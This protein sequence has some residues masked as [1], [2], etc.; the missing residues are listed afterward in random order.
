MAG[1]LVCGLNAIGEPA[2]IAPYLS[3]ERERSH[4]NL[5]TS[6]GAVACYFRCKSNVIATRGPEIGAST[7]SGDHPPQPRTPKHRAVEISSQNLIF[8]LFCM[9][10]RNGKLAHM[11]MSIEYLAS[12]TLLVGL[13]GR[14]DVAGAMEIDLPFTAAVSASRAVIVDMAQVDFLASIG[15]RTLILGAKSIMSKKGRIVLLRPSQNVES[16]LI[17][18]G[19]D[20]LIP[21]THD[22]ADA[23]RRVAD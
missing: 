22:R 1:P 21:I 12:G 17:A 2:L 14:L 23:E 15:L 16:V 18:S 4:I 5:S 3:S 9:Q 13:R 10:R 6:G 11:D 8:S 7:Y 20:T 19:T